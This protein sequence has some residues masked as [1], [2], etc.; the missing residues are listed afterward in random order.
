MLLQV[1][2]VRVEVLGGRG[3]RVAAAAVA[4]AEYTKAA[5]VP[6]ATSVFMSAAWCR[7][8]AQARV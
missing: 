8:A 5:P 4:I 2:E 6:T 1:S 7:K 3:E